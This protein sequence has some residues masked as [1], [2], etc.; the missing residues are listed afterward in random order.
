MGGLPEHIKVDVE[1][2]H[3]PDLHMTMYLARAF[4]RRVAAFLPA[5]QP[6]SS[7]TPSLP[8]PPPAP[9]TGSLVPSQQQSSLS[10]SAAAR[11]SIA[12]HRRSRLSDDAKSSTTIVM[13]PMSVAMC[14]S[15]SS[16]WSP[17]IIS[18]MTFP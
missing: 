10:T 1:I 3:P 14:V 2:R 12:S 16:S 17:R 13:S 18:L 8:R 6:C 7:R 4:K 15:D 5:L 11:G 9:S